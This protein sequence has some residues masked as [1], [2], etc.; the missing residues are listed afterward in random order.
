MTVP[1]QLSKQLKTIWSYIV[2]IFFYYVVDGIVEICELIPVW[3]LHLLVNNVE[4]VDDDGG[5]DGEH[6]KWTETGREGGVLDW[7]FGPLTS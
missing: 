6:N 7:F 5:G 2:I 1:N 3:E 4:A